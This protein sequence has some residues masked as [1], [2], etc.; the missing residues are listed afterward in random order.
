MSILDNFDSWKGFLGDRLE[1]AE[2]QGYD[3]KAISEIAFQIGGYLAEE[4]EGKN[5]E[6]R[7][8]AELWK[9]ADEKEQHAI[10]NMMVK[11]VKQGGNDHK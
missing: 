10:A 7:I 6:E 2:G 3:Q 5:E 11:L 9:V 8:L 4:V 1:H